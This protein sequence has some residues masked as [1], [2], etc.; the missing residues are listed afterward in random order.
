MCL[1]R[2]RAGAR[3]PAG[4]GLNGARRW[5]GWLERSGRGVSDGGRRRGEW[6]APGGVGGDGVVDGDGEAAAAAWF[7]V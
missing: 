7:D 3:G 5:W 6:A 4:A 2:R 1:K